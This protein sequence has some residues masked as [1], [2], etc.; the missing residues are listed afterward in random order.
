MMSWS[1]CERERGGGRGCGRET[2]K[3]HG[4]VIQTLLNLSKPFIFATRT[5]VNKEKKK[6]NCKR[7]ITSGDLETE[8]NAPILMQA[9][10]I[11]E[12]G[13]GVVSWGISPRVHPY[14]KHFAFQFYFWSR[15]DPITYAYVH[16]E[17]SIISDRMKQ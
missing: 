12:R 15:P 16:N 7:I 10:Q 14:F 8:R 13:D 4:N 6:E 11:H 1:V 3:H 5:A 17:M 9:T 2:R